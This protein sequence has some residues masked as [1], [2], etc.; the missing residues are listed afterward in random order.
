MSKNTT[1]ANILIHKQKQREQCARYDEIKPT[2]KGV[3]VFAQFLDTP[4]R[5]PKHGKKRPRSNILREGVQ[6]ENLFYYIDCNN[7]LKYAK[8]NKDGGAR[9][10]E[11]YDYNPEKW[12]TRLIK[13][14]LTEKARL[15]K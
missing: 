14:Y 2:Q 9:I 1:Q 10:T 3:V 5:K 8:I 6:V 12:D 11:T 15:S 13:V 7:E 4:A